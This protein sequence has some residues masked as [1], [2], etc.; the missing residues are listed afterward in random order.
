MLPYDRSFASHP[1]AEMWSDKNEK[2]T[3]GSY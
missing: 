1:M 2:T 3:S